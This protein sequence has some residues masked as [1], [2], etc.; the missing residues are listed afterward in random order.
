MTNYNNQNMYDM[1]IENTRA[2]QQNSAN[3]N[4]NPYINQSAN[5]N[6]SVQQNQAQNS[7]STGDFV[8]GALIGAAVTYFLTN[9]GAQENIMKAVS[10]GTQL[11]QAG[12]EEMKER[13]EDAKATME[14]NQE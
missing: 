1:N 4:Q 9:K 2:M 11:F 6:N 13:M 5:I 7:F 8:K 3:I 12:M 14:A 10:K